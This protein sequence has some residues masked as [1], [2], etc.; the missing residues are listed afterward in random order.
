MQSSMN[1]SGSLP[2]LG[3][4]ALSLLAA[5]LLL[6]LGLSAGLQILLLVVAAIVAP[7][8][9]N[10]L[11]QVHPAYTLSAAIFLSPVA[12][13][14][15][16][17]GFPSGADPDRLLLAFG[18][19]QVLFR[20]PP[21]RDRPRFRFTP[22][23]AFLGAALLY[24]L[25]SAYAAHTL[26]S[27][28]PFFD[29]IDTF[30]LLPFLA[31]LVA[32]L[33]FRTQRER[34]ILLFTLVALG[35]YLGLTTL[36]EMV[37]LNALVFPRY[38]NDPNYGIHYGMGRGPFVEATTNGFACFVC[39]AACGV[40][41]ATWTRPKARLA[42]G[43][44]G[45]LCVVGSF[46]S[47]ERSVWI[48]VVVASLVAMLVTPRL[49]RYLLP[50]VVIVGIAAG[51]AFT[52]IPSLHSTVNNRVNDVATVYDR[53]NLNAAALNMISARPLTGFGWS[54][55]QSDSLLYFHQSQNYPI[56]PDLPN[57]SIHNLLLTYAVELGLVGMALWGFGL[58]LGIGSALLARGPTD[59]GAWRVALVAVFT[60]FLVI[61]D[62]VPPSL[63]PSLSLWLLAG[64]AFS[65]R[66]A[67][68]QGT[69]AEESTDLSWA[70]GGKRQRV[71]AAQ[72][73]T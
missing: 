21:V 63:F 4:L 24:V 45:A 12:G 30:G 33:A 36:F 9:L 43:S 42:A 35:A 65:G 41:V 70:P 55:F 57:Y 11:W 13:N 29:I 62:A 46:L 1:R 51:V 25:V 3:A 69:V 54:T 67:Y 39:A 8:A 73:T 7:F 5:G 37:H 2:A 52:L 40:A 16:E 56:N 66:Y 14:W 31:F 60:I 64:V 50:A 10:L 17:V 58:L 20:A 18:I 27:K 53:E 32:P 19:L 71:I 26:F 68:D 23:H 59:L 47:L 48:G 28:A 61:S 44:I 34:R 22:A 72:G 15:H 38:I 49:R 6:T